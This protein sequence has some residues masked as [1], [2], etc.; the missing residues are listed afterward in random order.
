MPPA[1]SNILPTA[2]VNWLYNFETIIP[3]EGAM[4]I[5]RP[6]IYWMAVSP[7]GTTEF[8]LPVFPQMGDMPNLETGD[9]YWQ[10]MG[11]YSENESYDELNLNNLFNWK[12]RALYV[13]SFTFSRQN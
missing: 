1:A 13:S 8:D 7:G 10:L 5:S 6:I 12:S 4:P 9:Y 11:L 2:N 3:C